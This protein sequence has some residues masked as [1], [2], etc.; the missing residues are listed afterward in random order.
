MSIK[1]DYVKK[2]D[3]QITQLGAKFIGLKAKA[4]EKIA[5][6]KIAIKESIEKGKDEGKS[7]YEALVAKFNELKAAGDDKFEQL[8]DT[9]EKSWAEL[10]KKSQEQQKKFER[11]A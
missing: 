8:K 1:D 11:R 5:D 10:N 3:A 4:Q 6:S 7:E 2:M 9:V